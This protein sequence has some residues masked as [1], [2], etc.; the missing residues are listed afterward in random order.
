MDKHDYEMVEKEILYQGI[1]RLTRLAIRHRLF[2]G[3]WSPVVKREVLERK[4]AVAVLPYDPHLDRVI[5]IEQFRPGAIADPTSPWM[6][7]IVAGVF[8]RD[9]KPE[10]VAHRETAEE[11]G[12][13]VEALYPISEFFV[14][15]G[16]SNEYLYIFCGKIDASNIDGI[17]GL[18]NE[19]E[20]IRVLNVSA[21]EAFALQREGKIKTAPANVA[22]FWLMAYRE[23]M[24]EIWKK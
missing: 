1:F 8:D 18:E 7:E 24:R 15:P 23:K 2:K 19:N 21:D 20:D 3:G 6:L 16:G 22:L 5:L 9:E 14:S 17:H 13:I 11:A 4:S 12:A 10:E